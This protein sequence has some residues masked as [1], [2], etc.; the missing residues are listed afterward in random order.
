MEKSQKFQKIRENMEKF[1]INGMRQNPGKIEG[2]NKDNLLKAKETT[3]NWP[4]ETVNI[5]FRKTNFNYYE[6]PRVFLEVGEQMIWAKKYHRNTIN[7][8]LMIT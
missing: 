2:A 4:F 7:V 5:D 6:N 1:Q 8:A 3:I